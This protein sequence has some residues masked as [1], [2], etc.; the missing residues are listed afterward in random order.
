[1]ANVHACIIVVIH[2]GFCTLVL[3]FILLFVDA[4]TIHEL[5]L[6]PWVGTKGR[7]ISLRTNFFKVDIP[8]DLILYHYDVVIIPDAPRAIKRRVMQA[9]VQ[10]YSSI[11]SGQFPVFD[12]DKH[13]YCHK[14]LQ[15][16]MVCDNNRELTMCYFVH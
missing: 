16:S 12:G 14:R 11:F 8:S 1:M 10:K 7:P 4:V 13:L 5:P 3:S 9:A 6:R 2:Q 15:S